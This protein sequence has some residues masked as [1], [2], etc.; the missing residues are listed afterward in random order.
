MSSC[1]KH[2]AGFTLIELLI[3]LGILAVAAAVVF[4]ALN[5]TKVFHSANEA[6]RATDKENLVKAF[7]LYFFDQ[8][9]R[10]PDGLDV[11]P[12][13]LGTAPTGCGVECEIDGAKTVLPDACLDVSQPLSPYLNGL[14]VNPS[15][16]NQEKTY[17][18]AR[19]VGKVVKIYDC[20][21]QADVCLSDCSERCG[22]G[23][24][25][26][27]SCP[28]TCSG[29]TPYCDNN[30]T[31]CVAAANGLADWWQLNGN[32]DD[33]LGER[34]LE[35]IGVSPTADHYGNEGQAY[36]FSLN[37]Q[38]CLNLTDGWQALDYNRDFSLS[39]WFK[40]ADLNTWNNVFGYCGDAD[41]VKTLRIYQ[42]PN[43][44]RLDFT[45]SDGVNS[46]GAGNGNDKLTVGLWTQM[47]LTFQGGNGQVIKWYQNGQPQTNC[48][49]CSQQLN[50]SVYQGVTVA[51]FGVGSVMNSPSGQCASTF[52]GS[53][54]DVRFYNKALTAQE[55]ADLYN[56]TK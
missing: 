12:R 52:G 32:A 54:D 23:N 7:D 33:V 47:V 35:I 11:T 50:R 17:Y 38:Q 34:N 19:L 4:V 31:A 36:D 29:A 13:L 43:K 3:V 10:W 45:I 25:C 41:C 56:A 5:P 14:P 28:N 8:K 9:G 55:V 44:N 22:G 27:G 18:A 26:G 15:V 46:R 48:W 40:A 6:R 2:R 37:D 16:G 1:H 49:N 53:L 20:V 51:G 30:H 39:F 24:G 21:G 42:E